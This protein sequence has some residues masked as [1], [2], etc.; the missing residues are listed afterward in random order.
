M[1]FLLNI[2]V[3]IAIAATALLAFSHFTAYRAGKA[4]VRADFD[5]YKIVQSEE[6]ARLEKQYRDKE[7]DWQAQAAQTEESKNAEIEAINSRLSSALDSLRNRP[8]RPTGSAVPKASTSCKGTT[9]ASLS[10]E[11]ARFSI[12]EAARADRLRAAL[13]ACYAAYDSLRK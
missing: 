11:D 12:G 9:G 10:A 5:A 2:R 6:R 8:S 1:D 3:I 4:T 7:I 13:Q